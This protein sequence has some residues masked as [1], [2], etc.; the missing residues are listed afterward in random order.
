MNRDDII[1]MATESDLID[2]RPPYEKLGDALVR[3][4]ELVAA[5]DTELLQQLLWLCSKDGGW[6]LEEAANT[7]CEIENILL[8]RLEGNEEA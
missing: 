4:A 3:F 7:I 2:S 8:A 5:K 6:T 1:R